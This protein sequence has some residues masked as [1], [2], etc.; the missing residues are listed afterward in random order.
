MASRNSWS[1]H[2]GIFDN[3]SQPTQL[4]FHQFEPHLVSADDKDVI[5]IWDWE[6]NKRLHAFSNANPP[7]SKITELKLINEDD[8]ALL[9]TGSSEGIV[10][11]FRNYEMPDAEL[12]TSWRALSDLLPSNRSSGLVADWPGVDRA[13][14]V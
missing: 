11:I 6:E 3:I 14:P 5:T 13:S 12:V 1:N 9:M 8:K 7:N 4:L 10:R 2:C